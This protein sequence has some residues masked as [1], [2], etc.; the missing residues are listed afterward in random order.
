MSTAEMMFDDLV[1]REGWELHLAGW[2]DRWI[3]K[4]GEIVF[5]EVKGK[6]GELKSHQIETLMML[7]RQ[8]LSVRVWCGGGLEE[9]VT[10]EQYLKGEAA[11]L[12]KPLSP[13]AIYNYRA[14]I[15][16]LETFEATMP[17][18]LKREQIRE[19]I[20][21]RKAM[22]NQGHDTQ[23][24]GKEGEAI[25]DPERAK[26]IKGTQE[27][28]ERMAR[29]RAAGGTQPGKEFNDATQ[30]A[31]AIEDLKRDATA[32]LKGDTPFDIN[33]QVEQ[34]NAEQDELIQKANDELVE[35]LRKEGGEK[36]K[37]TG[38]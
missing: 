31:F 19:L 3:E 38:T 22:L 4:D 27:Y 26:W 8:G 1:R 18:G 10:V 35:R 23:A 14:E 15:K 34:Q 2:P 13:Q 7:D 24:A 29:I 17:D 20:R 37:A 9:M 25:L 21:R 12:F 5:V 28:N 33:E 30:E 11:R 36:G 32:I 6:Y 16:K